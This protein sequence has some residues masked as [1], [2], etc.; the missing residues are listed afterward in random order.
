MKT[1]AAIPCHNEGL[2][3]GSVV[4]KARKYVDE[5]LVVD[6]GS[7]DAT[8]EVGEEAGAVVVSYG[9]NKGKGSAVKTLL[10]YAVEHGFDVLVLLDGMLK[11]YRMI[12]TR[13]YIG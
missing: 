2:A 12:W 7:T 6:D 11:A 4:L 13:C 3:I 8:V 1:L 5:V 9:V 10:G